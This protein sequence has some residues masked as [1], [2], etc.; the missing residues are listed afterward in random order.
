MDQRDYPKSN[1]RVF[2][3]EPGKPAGGQRSAA[4]GQCAEKDS[5]IAEAV[6][7]VNF[8]RLGGDPKLEVELEVESRER[9][10]IE[11]LR[12]NKPEAVFRG[13]GKQIEL[14]LPEGIS[15]LGHGAKWR[16]GGIETEVKGN[17]VEHIAEDARKGKEHD[18]ASFG[19]GDSL[20]RQVCRELFFRR[21]GGVI[22]MVG[23]VESE[24]I[25]AVAPEEGNA[26]RDRVDLVEIE[27]EHE[28]MVTEA[29][30]LRRQPVVHHGA[31]VKAG[32]HVQMGSP[33]TA[34]AHSSPE[35]KASSWKP[36]LK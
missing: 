32:V 9:R 7:H 2:E 13:R 22:E 30:P 10:D 27:I 4:S 26:A 36:Y 5:F 18:P 28:D 29:V 11:M 1:E 23:V 34:R 24:D 35:V 33:V 14:F 25:P 12:R 20:E 3:A 6:I 15:H 31:F 17:G 16:T 8:E 21:A 19:N